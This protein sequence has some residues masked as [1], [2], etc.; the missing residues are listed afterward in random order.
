MKKFTISK[1]LLASIFVVILNACSK[2]ND[3]SST[4]GGC[5]DSTCT[6]PSGPHFDLAYV[7]TSQTSEIR[8]ITF[9]DENGTPETVHDM[10]SFPGGIK[11]MTVYDTSF[12]ARIMVTVGNMTGHP[13]GFRLEIHVNGQTKQ[14]KDFTVPSLSTYYTGIAEYDVQFD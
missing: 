12:K 13:V 9:N 11:E 8:S 7:I 2:S 4:G 5:H 3:M 6:T 1:I 14:I 10:N